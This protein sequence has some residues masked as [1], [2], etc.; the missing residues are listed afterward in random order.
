MMIS[1]RCRIA[2]FDQ[3]IVALDLKRSR[4]FLYDSVCSKA[5]AS[6]YFDRE[7]IDRSTT[8][9]PLIADGIIDVKL[10]QPL[11]S[12]QDLIADYRAMRFEK[13]DAGAWESRTIGNRQVSGLEILPYLRI[14]SSVMLLKVFGFGAL[15]TLERMKR[16]NACAVAPPTM[17]PAGTIERYL[18]AAMWSPFRI[19]CLPLSFSVAAHLRRKSIPAQLVI[20]VRPT[21]FVSHAWV[22]ID[23]TVYG[24]DQDLKKSYGEIY[25]TP[26]HNGSLQSSLAT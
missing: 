10:T 16:C 6:Y 12:R 13:F 8:L 1:R 11:T 9:K 23:K 5:F 24:D 19:T 22:E 7:K 20:G 25:R 14:M 21:P 3:M 26:Q 2:V 18:S 4:Y 15:S 17:D